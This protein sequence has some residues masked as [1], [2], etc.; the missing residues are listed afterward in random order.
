MALPEQYLMTP[1]NLNSFL[2]SLV[3]AQPPAKFTT[4]FLEQLEFKSTNDR[5]FIGV[6]KALGFIDSNGTPQERY[7]KF[8][9]QTQSKQILAESIR[10]AYSDL[11]AVNLKA[12]ELSES[13]VKNKLKLASRC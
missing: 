4:K 6:L 13:E 7:F 1:K 8:I 3:N 11:F 10:E 2:N 5:L 9:D 12:N